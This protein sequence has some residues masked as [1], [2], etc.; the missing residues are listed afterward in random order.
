MLLDTEETLWLPGRG[1]VFYLPH[2]ANALQQLDLPIEGE[3][4]VAESHSGSIWLRDRREIRPVRKVRNPDGRAV[5]SNDGMLF[6][7]DDNLWMGV[8]QDVGGLIELARPDALV[9][10][11]PIYWRDE[12][13]L[14]AHSTIT[15][16]EILPET[17]LEDQEGNVWVGSLTG[18]HKFS[19]VNAQQEFASGY[20]AV[21][22]APTEDGGLWVG[23][24]NEHPLSK[25]ENGKFTPA[26]N[27]P[28]V[29][30][31]LR[32][33][34]GSL[35]L[36]TRDGIGHLVG[37][38]LDRIAS[39][40]TAQGH[41]VQAMA[42]D[43]SGA[44]FI[45]I[46]RRGV[47]RLDR[48]TWTAY[49][50]L[51]DLPHETAVTLSSDVSGR[52]WVGYTQNRVAIIDGDTV[53]LFGASDGLQ[54]GNVTAIY[55]RR[56]RV[57]VGGEFG[58]ALFDG[59][60]F[61]P[62][63]A[64]SPFQLKR[65]TGIIETGAGDLWLNTDTGV[66]HIGATEL[67]RVDDRTPAHVHG[68]TFGPLD[69][70]GGTPSPLRPHPT[71]VEGTDGR[72]WFVT[73]VA[74]F[75]IDPKHLVHN[76]VVPPVVV[77]AL[78]VGEQAYSPTQGVRLPENSTA[79]RIDYAGLSLT[80][81][82]KVRYRYK[83]DGVDRVWQNAEER[84]EAYFVNLRPGS[85]R[86]HVIASN[87]DGVWNDRG[88]YLDF[89]IPPTFVQTP[90]FI[91]L[92]VTGAGALIGAVFRIR[93]RQLGARMRL[94]HNERLRE[95]ERIARELHDTLL[96]STQG[97]MLRVQA[98]TN[99]LPAGD[100]ARAMLDGALKRADEVLA[101]AGDRVQD[102]RIPLEGRGDLAQSLTA[103]GNELAL[104]RAVEFSVV[105][106]GPIRKLPT[107]V[108]DETYRIGR[109][110]LLNA[111]HHAQATSVQILIIYGG[112]DLTVRIADDGCGI[113]K[114]ILDD[115]YRAGHWG[116]RG[117]HERAAE[118]GGYLEIRSQRGA[119]T[120]INL[121][122]PIVLSMTLLRWPRFGRF[123]PRQ[124][125]DYE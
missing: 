77:T 100:A 104:G 112:K 63:F 39:P 74:V 58:L 93:I 82:Q 60:R 123:F 2:R 46:I 47:F 16:W 57:W 88:T 38:R 65:I 125:K 120:A 68:E 19:R 97:L 61:R 11:G 86:F 35:W 72:L 106:E 54:I 87:N 85:Y 118:I 92:C 91:V 18:L 32:A 3:S 52:V 24:D 12:Q 90:W 101:E 33:R 41:E 121:Q 102:L 29:S 1:R 36:G 25:F 116:L 81:P 17:T 124:A 23:R 99:R 103:V 55:G 50:D 76:S 109:E 95:R 22:L 83:L 122:V 114:N 27:V 107:R 79:L 80:A 71:A 49:G 26:A 75:S 59:K 44:M 5:H 51:P 89:V 34:D 70:L 56:S 98:A 117:M 105:V 94:R 66:A 4:S 62:V 14:A 30:C 6:D 108:V 110:A 42:E 21:A 37:G 8:G 13:Y 10:T 64:E 31:L 48:D 115:G 40:P 28:Y 113:A 111:F 78:H 53:Q 45:S 73:S 119:G 96:Q 69:G 67:R 43:Q 9:A 15:R 7:R 84:D 20:G